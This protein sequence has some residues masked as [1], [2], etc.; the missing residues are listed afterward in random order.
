MG[1]ETKRAGFF[2]RLPI[3]GLGGHRLHFAAEGFGREE[4]LLRTRQ[5]GSKPHLEKS[6]ARGK[7]VP[8]NP[9]L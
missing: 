3:N 9:S 2:E 5:E 1:R 7:R 4:K 8:L 6:Q